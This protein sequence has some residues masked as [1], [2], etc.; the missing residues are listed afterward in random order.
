MLERGEVE[1]GGGRVVGMDLA[2]ELLLVCVC[3]LD[4]AGVARRIEDLTRE[5]RGYTLSVEEMWNWK[6]IRC[7]SLRLGWSA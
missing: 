5:R 3:V 2:E 6:N 4:L 7:F 1:I